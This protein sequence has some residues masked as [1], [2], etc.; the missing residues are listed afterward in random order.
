M[1]L[2]KSKK[3]LAQVTDTTSHGNCHSIIENHPDMQFIIG[4]IVESSIFLSQSGQRSKVKK[5][6][7]LFTVSSTIMRGGIPINWYKN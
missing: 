6:K 5:F 7:D 2:W 4:L 3:V 1:S